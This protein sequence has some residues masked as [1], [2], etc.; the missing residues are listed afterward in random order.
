MFITCMGVCFGMQRFHGLID[1]PCLIMRDTL[2]FNVFLARNWGQKCEAS[3]WHDLPLHRPGGVEHWKLTNKSPGR[4]HRARHVSRPR[5]DRF[6]FQR[7]PRVY[8]EY[9]HSFNR[10]IFCLDWSCTESRVETRVHQPCPLF[11]LFLIW[12]FRLEQSCIWSEPKS[13]FQLLPS[14]NILVQSSI[15]SPSTSHFTSWNESRT[16]PKSVLRKARYQSQSREHEIRDK[17]G[18]RDLFAN[19]AVLK[20]HEF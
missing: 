7:S 20:T 5:D 1:S 19:H 16:N 13:S 15:S 11:F 14:S 2:L 6:K 17:V 4:L 3:V 10:H 9:R 18:S 12:L 8:T